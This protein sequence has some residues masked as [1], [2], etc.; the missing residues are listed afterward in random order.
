M[1]VDERSIMNADLHCNDVP[2]DVRPHEG[3]ENPS[4]G[5]RDHV[6]D[7]RGDLNAQDSCYAKQPANN[8]LEDWDQHMLSLREY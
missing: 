3:L 5:R 6:C 2:E 4:N 1:K 8:S 7:W